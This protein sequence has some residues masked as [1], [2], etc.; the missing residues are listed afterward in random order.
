MSSSSSHQFGSSASDLGGRFQKYID[1]KD[2]KPYI[3]DEQQK[4]CDDHGRAACAVVLIES[5]QAS[6]TNVCGDGFK[7]ET[8]GVR[9]AA[10]KD[11]LAGYGSMDGLVKLDPPRSSLKAL[12]YLKLLSGI[13]F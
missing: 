4:T 1:P 12:F 6:K 11:L 2:M 5:T 8:T 10:A 3:W 7:M 13:L 9:D